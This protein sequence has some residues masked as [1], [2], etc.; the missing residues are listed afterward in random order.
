MPVIVVAV[1]LWRRAI[2]G[3]R[4]PPILALG[5]LGVGVLVLSTAHYVEPYAGVGG[6]QLFALL[7]IYV[8]SLAALSWAARDQGGGISPEAAR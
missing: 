8:A 4:L 3:R 7:L 6:Q 1:T 5:A 2:D